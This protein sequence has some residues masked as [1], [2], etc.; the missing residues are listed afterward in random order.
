MKDS[1]KTPREQ[2]LT[3][4]KVKLT[5]RE[6]RELMGMNRSTYERRRGSVRQK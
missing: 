5:D 3:K 1:K 4:P 6:L 2:K